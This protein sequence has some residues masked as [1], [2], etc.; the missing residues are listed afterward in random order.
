MQHKWIGF[1]YDVLIIVQSMILMVS[2]T[3]DYIYLACFSVFLIC[4][5][6]NLHFIL[7]QRKDKNAT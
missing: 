4:W 6:V 1:I 5:I 2:I 7:C 3:N